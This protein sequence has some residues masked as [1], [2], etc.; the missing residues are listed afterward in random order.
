MSGLKRGSYGTV[1]LV[2]AAL[3]LP[4]AVHAQGQTAFPLL[5]YRPVPPPASYLGTRDQTELPVVQDSKNYRRNPLLGAAIGAVIGAMAGYI[6][7]PGDPNTTRTRG[8]SALIGA[9]VGAA[10]GLVIG[11]FIKTPN[12]PEPSASAAIP[13][14]LAVTPAEGGA[15][16]RLG[17]SYAW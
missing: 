9:G 10:V 13:N 15:D 17:W 5:A 2:L 16:V 1:L 11:Y 8:E 4:S 12:D 14:T 6:S 3:L 7:N